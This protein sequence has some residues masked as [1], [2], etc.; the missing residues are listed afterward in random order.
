MSTE[1]ARIVMMESHTQNKEGEPTAFSNL[2][3]E[4]SIN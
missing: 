4:V 3:E 1:S 2:L